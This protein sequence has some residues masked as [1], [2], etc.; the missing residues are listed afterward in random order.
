MNLTKTLAVTLAAASA[1]T[2]SAFA[3]EEASKNSAEV[4]VGGAFQ[5]AYVATGTT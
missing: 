2:S 4:Y 5:S 1:I 3:E